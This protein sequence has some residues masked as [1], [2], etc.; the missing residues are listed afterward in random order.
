MAKTAHQGTIAA[1]P[2]QRMRL[3]AR[4]I[5]ALRELLTTSQFKPGD[6]LPPERSLAAA[7][8]VSR[9]LIREALR[10]L[11]ADGWVLVDH[12]R[13]IFVGEHVGRSERRQT[14][15]P[16]EQDGDFAVA[17]EARHVFEA[18][19]ADLVAER[20]TDDDIRSLE[21]IYDE[22]RRQ[23]EQGQ[24]AFDQDVAFHERILQSTHNDELIVMGRSAV[25]NFMR[26]TAFDQPHRSLLH[27]HTVNL[28]E[29]ATI[30]RYI[31]TR[32]ADRLRCLL[33]T[34]ALSDWVGDQ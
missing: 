13:G 20:A 34:F 19:L 9:S 17:L 11:E 21:R 29:H 14:S 30:L 23:V 5:D 12:G 26:Q 25:I 31:K 33:R 2:L 28:D 22:M 24:P 3:S 8:A 27:P 10:V 6:R 18:G 32:D 4:L 16:G 1:R 15:R 7:F